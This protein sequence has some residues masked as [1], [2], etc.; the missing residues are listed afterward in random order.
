[1]PNPASLMVGLILCVYWA[2]VVRLLRKAHQA[3]RSANFIP[4]EP[5]GRLMRLIW[6]PLVL[7][8]IVLPLIEGSG[9]GRHQPMLEPLFSLRPISWLAVSVAFVAL[10]LTMICWKEMGKSWRMGINPEE[11]TQ[12]IATGPYAYIRHPVYALSSML[13]LTTV[14]VDPSPL[15]I[16]VALLHLGL[17][18]FEARREE[19]YLL[20]THGTI[21]QEYCRRVG[22][23]IP[24][25]PWAGALKRT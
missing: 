5:V 6:I 9:A 25:L 18:Q 24:R 22:G 7:L 12:L 10:V 20:R 11:K 2:R 3:G 1:M 13:M 23:F 15:M 21:Y 4:P 19:G 16:A 17:L 14:V 8:W